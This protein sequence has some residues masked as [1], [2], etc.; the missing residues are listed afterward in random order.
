MSSIALR[1]PRPAPRR[2]STRH[3]S[4]SPST[5]TPLRTFAVHRTHATADFTEADEDDD[6]DDDEGRRFE[7]NG[8]NN[9]NSDNNHGIATGLFD[10]NNDSNIRRRPGQVYGDDNAAGRDQGGRGDDGEEDRLPR[11]RNTL[12]V[13]P[14]FSSTHLG[15]SYTS[16]VSML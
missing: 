9:S 14:L 8:N 10:D 7:N 1:R 16:S 13:L 11:R 6:E 4:V 15:M 5:V 12:P 3:E 2:A